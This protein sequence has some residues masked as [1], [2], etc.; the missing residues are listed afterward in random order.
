MER[1]YFKVIDAERI[2]ELAPK[3]ELIQDWVQ[4]L[5]DHPVGYWVEEMKLETYLYHSTKVTKDGWW[6]WNPKKKHYERWVGTGILY[7]LSNQKK[8]G[9][10]FT[11][12]TPHLRWNIGYIGPGD[13][14]KVNIAQFIAWS[15]HDSKDKL[16]ETDYNQALAESKTLIELK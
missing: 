5:N 11:D 3:P 8:L 7:K 2:R 16:N 13:H 12:V 9:G 15:G 10:F 14:P 4:W 1:K 6:R